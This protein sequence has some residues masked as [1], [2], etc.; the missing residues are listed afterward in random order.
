MAGKKKKQP[1]KI[2]NKH[3]TSAQQ[4]MLGSKTTSTGEKV[5][6]TTL[7]LQVS[8]YLFKGV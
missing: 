6:A 8:G 4:D 3:E 1:E 7:L 2:T 5:T